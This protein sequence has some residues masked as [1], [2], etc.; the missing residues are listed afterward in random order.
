MNKTTW[1]PDYTLQRSPRAKR[2]IFKVSLKHGLI[3]VI[4]KRYALRHIPPAMEAARKSDRQVWFKDE[5]FV[6]TTIYQRDRLP[7]GATFDGPAI[8]EQPD[9]TTVLP[10]G[11]H[12]TVDDY[13]NLVI[14][15][16]R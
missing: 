14:K 8:V 12:C 7:R 6:D 11:T 9:T 5:G 15:V 3:V 4:P 10:P 2:I 1:P 13:G 16:D